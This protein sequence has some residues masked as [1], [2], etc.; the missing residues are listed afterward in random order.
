M[1][2]RI[3][4]DGRITFYKDGTVVKEADVSTTV[5]VTGKQSHCTEVASDIN[6]PGKLE[7]LLCSSS[8]SQRNNNA[9][10]EQQCCVVY[11][12]VFPMK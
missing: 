11:V 1:C 5:E 8:S 7:I 2:T 4:N 9:D 6:G 10:E 3:S 12:E